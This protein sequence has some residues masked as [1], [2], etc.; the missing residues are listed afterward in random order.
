M[1]YDYERFL[2][3]RNQQRD[4]TAFIR[5]KALT[6]KQISVISS[7]LSYVND[8][9]GLSAEWPSLYCFP[10]GE[11]V[12]LLRHYDSGRKHAGR[13]IGVLEGV[14][15]KRTRARHFARAVPH[16]LTHQ[17]ELLAAD[18]PDVD[19]LLMPQESP[20]Y[21]WPDAQIEAAAAPGVGD[22]LVNEFVARLNEDRLFLPF[23]EDGWALLLAALSDPRFPPLYFAFGTNADVIARLNKAEI[24]VDVVS[25]LN[26]TTP[27]L[28]SRETNEITSELTNYVMRPKP[29]PH[30]QPKHEVEEVPS[31]RSVRPPR[32]EIEPRRVQDDPLAHYEGG[33]ILT[34]REMQRRQREEQARQGASHEEHTRSLF[35]RLADLLGRLLG[36]K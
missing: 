2:F 4:F 23:N 20:E 32:V 12:L 31:M 34:P 18:V 30:V 9:S 10:V 3:T 11:Y 24:D 27:S 33:E 26:T 13:N 29:A 15:V 8:V 21:P 19:A 25:Y 35:G 1:N 14:A 22:E 5:P 17:A 28:R 7:A 36:K 6:N 16:F